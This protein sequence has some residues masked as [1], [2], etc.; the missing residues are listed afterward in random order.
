MSGTLNKV[1]EVGITGLVPLSNYT[2]ILATFTGVEMTG[3]G[4]IC[5]LSVIRYKKR[6]RVIPDPL[7][8]EVIY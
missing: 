2:T 6:G 8:I 7:V 1:F 3:A 4:T 5:L